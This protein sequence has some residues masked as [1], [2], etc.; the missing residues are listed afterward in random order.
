VNTILRRLG[1]YLIAAWVSLSLNFV[2]PRLM[3]GDPAAALMARFRGQISPEAMDALRVA[4]GSSDA[5]LIVQYFQYVGHLL[6]GQLGLSIAHFPAPVTEVISTGLLWTVYLAGGAVFVSFCLGTCLGV[7]SAWYRGS[8]L[9]R[10]LPPI[11]VFLGAF[12]YFWLAMLGLLSF[13]LWLG[14][15]PMRHAYDDA[16]V[17]S[18][19]WEFLV[20]IAQHSILPGAAIVVATLGGWMLNMR[21]TMVGVLGEDYIAMARAKGLGTRRT[22]FTYAAR[23]ALLPNVTGFGMAL[24]FVLSGSLLTEIVFSYPGL[25]Y[26]LI[27]AVHSQDYPLLQGLFLCVTFAVLGANWLVDIVYVML[28]PRARTH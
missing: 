12:P 28:D 14:W 18:W 27:E 16:L 6:S 9:D 11:L 3:P 10:W 26:L 21:N 23:N 15:L 24:G 5:P 19:S 25:G 4:F 1:F 17:P 22:M 8:R 13:G 20:S 2:V 7:L